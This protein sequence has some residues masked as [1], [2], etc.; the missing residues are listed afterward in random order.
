MQICCQLTSSR[1]CHSSPSFPFISAFSVIG[2]DNRSRSTYKYMHTGPFEGQRIL[3]GVFPLLF[4]L[5]CRSQKLPVPLRRPQRT[6]TATELPCRH[7]WTVFESTFP[8]FLLILRL[9]AVS[10]FRLAQPCE[11]QHRLAPS[12]LDPCGFASPAAASPG[13]RSSYLGP[14]W[15][16]LSNS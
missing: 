8:S 11:G 13:L 7:A 10:F 2:L 12:K 6:A 16:S 4:L 1:S 15:S 9:N 14:A 5:A 3:A